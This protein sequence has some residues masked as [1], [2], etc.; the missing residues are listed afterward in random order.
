MIVPG[1]GEVVYPDFVSRQRV[2]I[3]EVAQVARM[4]S[5][6]MSD[7]D[8]EWAANRLAVGGPAGFLA[9]RRAREHLAE[10]A[11]SPPS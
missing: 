8:L 10:L 6:D 9:L 1:H 3:A 4:L 7:Q 5:P 2:D 11:P